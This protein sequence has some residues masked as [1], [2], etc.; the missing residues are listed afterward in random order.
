MYYICTA[1]Y[2]LMKI[3]MQLHVD[4]TQELETLEM[5]LAA[6]KRRKVQGVELKTNLRKVFTIIIVLFFR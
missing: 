1:Q 4:V 3:F 6:L 2:N 5:E